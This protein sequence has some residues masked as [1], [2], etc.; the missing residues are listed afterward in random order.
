MMPQT[1]VTHLHSDTLII[2]NQLVIPVSIIDGLTAQ[3]LHVIK[4]IAQ[5]ERFITFD[6]QVWFCLMCCLI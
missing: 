4:C 5:E 1:T 6:Q 2:Y 3:P